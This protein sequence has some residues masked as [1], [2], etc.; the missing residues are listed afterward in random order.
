VFDCFGAGQ[1]VTQMTFEGGDWRGNPAIATSMFKVFM[2]MR[3]LKELLWYL[4]EALTLLPAGRLRDQV[5]RAGEQTECLTHRSAE[6]LAVVDVTAQRQ[7]VG[8]LLERVSQVVRAQVSKRGPDRRSANLIGANLRGVN[9]RG[10]SLRG[11]YLL[12][13]DLRGANLRRADLLGADLRAAD[14]RAA[15]LD[16]AIFCTQPQL[17]AATGDTSTTIPSALVRPRHWPTC[18]MPAD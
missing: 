5:H 18:A 13:A 6:E 3:Q 7:Q 15:K 14:L 9:L 11:A 12:S 4:A 2:V 17:D 16:G 10:A 1:H 8:P